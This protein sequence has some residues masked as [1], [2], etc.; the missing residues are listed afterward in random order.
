MASWLV[1]L[2]PPTPTP[3]VEGGEVDLFLPNLD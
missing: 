2:Q 1:G 3:L